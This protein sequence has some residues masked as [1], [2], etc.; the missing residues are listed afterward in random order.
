MPAQGSVS[1]ETRVKALLVYPKHPSMTYWS[2]AG[3]LPYIEK[4]A[5]LPPLGL[6]TV[7][8]MLPDHWEI[9]LIDMNVSPISDADIQWSD[10]VMTSTM[11]VQAPSHDELVTRCKRLGV[12]VVAGGPHPT[13]SSH[14]MKDVDHIFIGEAEDE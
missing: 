8:A 1:E 13:A 7:A 6:I 11:I 5:A 14:R 3:S 9:R 12:P 4:R 2:F 10:L